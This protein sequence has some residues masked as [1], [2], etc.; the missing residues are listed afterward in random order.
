M[1]WAVVGAGYAGIAAAAS[2]LSE[3]FQVDVLDQREEVGGLWLDGVYPAVRLITTAE[4]TAYPDRPMSS[5]GQFPSG[6]EMLAYLQRV[7]QETGV[8]Q[9]LRNQ[10]VSKIEPCDGKW[11][12]DGVSY[13][14]VVL[15]TGLYSEPNIPNVPG[16]S[17]IPSL[18]TASYRGVEQLGDN[19][20][21]V[22][23]G[24]SGADVA[25]DC[26][27]AGKRVTIVDQR[28]RHV[29]PK[30]I[31]RQPVVDLTRPWFLPDL[32]VRVAMD[33]SVR[34]LSAKSR[35]GRLPEPRHLLL[36]ETPVVH[37]ALLPLLR[38]GSIVARSGL[39]GINGSVADFTDGSSGTY[40]TVVWATGYKY[41]L[42]IER[43]LVDGSRAGY[44]QS[45]LSLVG[46]VWSPVSP[47]LACVGFRE[48]RHGRGFYLH[49]A[50]ELTAAG[51]QAQS[52]VPGPIGQ[53]L[54]KVVGPSATE[55]IDDGPEIRR[56]QRLTAVARQ[57]C[58]SVPA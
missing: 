1:T 45:P 33:V 44:N 56:I 11:C 49:A 6:D 17:T 19:V 31:L 53:E 35:R 28:G 13:D 58:G 2:L 24:N 22:G 23:M 7:A 10:K 48:P 34:F 29:I 51:A 18:H 52:F 3:G 14:G 20:L 32:P 12:V 8:T 38:D 5:D 16:N 47:A 26:A 27:G 36:S 57:L 39:A 50:A 54:A 25:Q 40:E 9:Q 37:S 4:R 30:R 42:P 15:A 55:L 21:V 46:G 43:A 41:R